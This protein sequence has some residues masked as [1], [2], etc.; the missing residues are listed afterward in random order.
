MA[1]SQSRD[2]QSTPVDTHHSQTTTRAHRPTRGTAPH[3]PAHSIAEL[4]VGDPG[5]LTSPTTPQLNNPRLNN[6]RLNNPRL[7]N[8]QLDGIDAAEPVGHDGASE[9]KHAHNDASSEPG[10]EEAPATPTA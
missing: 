7:N 5:Q 2:N 3:Q 4:L 10:R 1:I 9:A 8:P 6:P